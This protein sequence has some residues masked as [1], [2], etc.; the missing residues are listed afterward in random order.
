MLKVCAQRFRYA[1]FAFIHTQTYFEYYTLTLRLASLVKKA[2]PGF[3]N[4]HYWSIYFIKSKLYMRTKIWW[5]YVHIRYLVH[6]QKWTYWALGWPYGWALN[7]KSDTLYMS[8]INIM[9]KTGPSTEP[10]GT[11]QTVSSKL[12]DCSFSITY[13]FLLASFCNNKWWLTVS[14]AFFRSINTTA[15]CYLLSTDSISSKAA[16]TVDLCFYYQHLV[17][18]WLD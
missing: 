12:G 14:K 5:S 3:L 17:Y 8:L 16:C 13:C 4:L 7:F 9:N 18:F 6:M 1:L 10:C 2:G 15:Q 11:P